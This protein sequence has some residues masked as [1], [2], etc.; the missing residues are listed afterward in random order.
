LKAATAASRV[1]TSPMFVRSRPSRTRAERPIPGDRVLD[2][3]DRALIGAHRAAFA[4]VA[5]YLGRAGIVQAD[6]LGRTLGILAVTAAEANPTEGDIL[7]LGPGSF[8]IAPM[9]EGL[10]GA[11]LRALRPDRAADI[12]W[13]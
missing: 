1:K 6:E 4:L 13:V 3:F 5:A 12:Q 7:G 10:H 11:S 9:V 2:A 8:L